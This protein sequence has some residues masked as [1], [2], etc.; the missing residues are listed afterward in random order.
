[1]ELVKIAF[2][3]VEHLPASLDHVEI[4]KLQGN[5]NQFVLWNMYV[6]H[7]LRVREHSSFSDKHFFS[8]NPSQT[9]L[10]TRILECTLIPQFLLSKEVGAVTWV[11]VCTKSGS[12]LLAGTLVSVKVLMYTCLI[13]IFYTF[14][15]I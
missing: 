14:L 5:K 3:W 11:L 15:A 12:L 6:V 13:P 4:N 9:S 7:I 10:G 1:M 2:F 8:R